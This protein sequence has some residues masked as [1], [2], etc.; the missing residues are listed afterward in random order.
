MM[1]D[2]Q[3][4]E[5]FK[6][7]LILVGFAGLMAGMFFSLLFMT[8]SPEPE[9]HHRHLKFAMNPDLTG[10][11]INRRSQMSA[12]ATAPSQPSAP[13]TL[14]NPDDALTLIKAW[15]PLTWDLSAASAK[16]SQEKALMYMTPECASAYRQNIWTDDMANQIVQ[17]GLQTTFDANQVKAGQPQPDGTIVIF[18]DGLQTMT[19]AGKGTQQRPV[20]YEYLIKLTQDGLRIAGISEGGSQS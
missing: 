14:V 1:F 17:C 8:P 19:V 20:K 12:Q 2:Y 6:L 3:A 5:K 10:Q 16:N 9:R 18:V 15:L 11:P 4:G 13:V 7:T